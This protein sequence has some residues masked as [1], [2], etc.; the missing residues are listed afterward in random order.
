M[1]LYGNIEQNV[2]LQ[3]IVVRGKLD[4]DENLVKDAIKTFSTGKGRKGKLV[5]LDFSFENVVTFYP[6][7][8]VYLGIELIDSDYSFSDGTF[9]LPIIC[10]NKE[11][12][13][14]SSFRTKSISDEITEQYHSKTFLERPFYFELKVVVK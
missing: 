7:E 1:I 8:L 2:V 14:M 6:G 4:I 3:P 9:F 13:P 11:T 5:P 12:I 10:Y